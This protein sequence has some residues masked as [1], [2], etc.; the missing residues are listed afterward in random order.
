MSSY[1]ESM[2]NQA[3]EKILWLYREGANIGEIATRMD[4]SEHV[5]LAIIE[6]HIDK[7]M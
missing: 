1:T 7:N 3:Y 4:L 2:W 5:V 6:K